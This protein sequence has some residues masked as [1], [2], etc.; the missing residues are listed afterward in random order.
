[1]E[2]TKQ[3]REEFYA[4]EVRLLQSLFQKFL[5]NEIPKET[6]LKYLNENELGEMFLKETLGVDIEHL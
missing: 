2:I 1:M 3:Q 5:Q 4:L 6:F